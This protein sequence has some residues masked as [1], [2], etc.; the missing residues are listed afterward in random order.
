MTGLRTAQ[1]SGPLTL[2]TRQL[3]KPSGALILKGRSR[4]RTKVEA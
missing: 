1:S 2:W 3:G 4:W